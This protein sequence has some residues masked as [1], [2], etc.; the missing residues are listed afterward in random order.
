MD[1]LEDTLGQPGGGERRRPPLGDQRGLAR[2][3]QHD[4]VAGD[5]RRQDGV[6]RREEG[7]VPRGEDEHGAQRL[8]SD[9]PLEPGFRFNDRVGEGTRRDGGH[10]VGSLLEP[11]ADLRRAVGDGAAHLPRQL[12]GDRLGVVDHPPHHPPA[13]GDALVERD[14]APGALRDRRGAEHGVDVGLGGERSGDV[15]GPVDGADRV[16]LAGCGHARPTP[17]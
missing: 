14:L 10:V 12:L 7:V 1:V 2:H 16:L 13:H 8:P 17:E 3:L 6:H 15:H 11:A 4:G 9:E 5:D